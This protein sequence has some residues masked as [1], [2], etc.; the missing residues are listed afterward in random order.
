VDYGSYIKTPQ[1][2]PQ[3]EALPGREAEMLPNAAGGVGFDTGPWGQLQRFLILGSEGGTYYASQRDLTMDNI[4][5]VGECL[6]LNGQRVVDMAVEVSTSGRALKN[7]PAIFTLV[8][9]LQHKGKGYSDGRDTEAVKV[10]RAAS[11]AV[12]KVCRTGTHLFTFA[13]YLKGFGGWNRVTKG[14]FQKWYLGKSEAD[15]AYQLIKYQQ[16]GGWS[17][18]DV[19]RRARIAPDTDTR[20]ALFHWAVKGWEDVGPKPHED[21]VLRRVWAFETAKRATNASEV[22]DLIQTY[23]LPRECI[24]TELLNSTEVW[25]AL[26]EKMPLGAMIRNLGKMSKLGMLDNMSDN[27]KFVVSRITDSEALRRARIHP[28]NVLAALKTYSQGRG[29]RGSNTWD[30]TPK[31]VDALDDAFYAA[32]ENV[33]PTGKR[34]CL[35]LDVSGSMG[36]PVNGLEMLTNYEA[37]AAMA[38]CIMRTE[39]NWEAMA[40]SEGFQPLNISPKQR[41]DDVLKVMS[42]LS[43]SRTDCSVPFRWA[44]TNGKRFDAFAVMTDSETYHSGAHPS[45]ELAN[46][47]KQT[48]IPARSAVLAF[49]STRTTIAD[50][51]DPGMLDIVGC[52]AQVPQLFNQFISG[53]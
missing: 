41:L 4:S 12:P 34:I 10:R 53:F 46:Y 20:N 26:L 33:T 36:Q 35:A 15:L 30:V 28:I 31:I 7:D 9:A 14:A 1:N 24:P 23:N 13:Q 2:T 5:C 51:Q 44:R 52:D 3:T 43:F 50:P 11:E 17:H 32:F 25:E 22:V 6:K 40:F 45:V 42:R 37:S 21:E 29:F 19:L 38:M 8:L 27:T 18:R 47:R 16:R 48:G 49:T 39:E